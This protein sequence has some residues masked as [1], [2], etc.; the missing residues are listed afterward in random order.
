[1]SDAITAGK[2]CTGSTPRWLAENFRTVEGLLTIQTPGL[3]KHLAGCWGPRCRRSLRVSPTFC[4]GACAHLFFL[5]LSLS[6]SPT[7]SPPQPFSKGQFNRLRG[8][9]ENVVISNMLLSTI[10]APNLGPS[11]TSPPPD[12]C[13]TEPN[14]KYLYPEVRQQTHFAFSIGWC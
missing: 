5:S 1:M 7:A 12:Y 14:V 10:Q 4:S 3:S 2:T 13:P 11:L 6:L 8:R 9:V